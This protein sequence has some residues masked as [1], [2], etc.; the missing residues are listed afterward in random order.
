TSNYLGDLAFKFMEK[1][2][3]QWSWGVF[4]QYNISKWFSTR[5]GYNMLRIQGDDIF[6]P[7]EGRRARYANFRNNVQELALT[8][9]FH[10]LQYG[11]S[12]GEKFS[13]SVYIGI[14]GFHHNPMA[15]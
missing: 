1:S 6:D 5:L 7:N 3:F 8:L 13:P 9:H 11:I 10:L 4:G 15:R 12:K 14:A 2:Q